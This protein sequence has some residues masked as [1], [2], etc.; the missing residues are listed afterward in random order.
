MDGKELRKKER[1]RSFY[2]GNDAFGGHRHCESMVNPISVATRKYQ[3]MLN[4]LLLR[5]LSQRARDILTWTPGSDYAFGEGWSSK[6]IGIY[7]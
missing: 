2:G 4:T 5:V 3:K 6:E 1:P 7:C